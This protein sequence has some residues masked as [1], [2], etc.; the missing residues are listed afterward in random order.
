[1]IFARLMD[2]GKVL[3]GRISSKEKKGSWIFEERK[4]ERTDPAM[5]LQMQDLPI[6]IDEVQG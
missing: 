2:A 4:L 5:F 6:L 3:F 1:M